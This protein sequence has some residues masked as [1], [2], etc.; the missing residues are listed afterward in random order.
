MRTTDRPLNVLH[1]TMGAVLGGVTRYICDLSNGM[2]RLGHH[3][4]ASG[5]P[6]PW[7]DL[8]HRE[9]IEWL[10][11]PLDGGLPALW[12]A[13]GRISRL[14]RER[15]ID[16]LHCH[17]RRPLLACKLA[18][19][20]GMPRAPLLYTLHLAPVPIGLSG[21]IVG[22]GDHVIAPATEGQNWITSVGRVDPSSVTLIAHGI[23]LGK[24]RPPHEDE[25]SEARAKFAV[26]GVGV[27]FVGRFEYPKNEQWVLDLAAQCRCTGTDATF[28]MCGDGPNV[29]KVHDRI[30]RDEL[31]QTVRLL[32]YVEPREVYHAADLVVLPSSVEGFGYVAAE[33]AACGVAVLRT[34]TAGWQE[35]VLDNITGRVV[36]IDREQFITEGLRLIRET[37][38]LRKMGDAG[39]DFARAHLSL[40]LQVQKTAFLYRTKVASG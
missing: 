4:L 7:E 5:A 15:N 26:C 17:F 2:H 12:A 3:C 1:L 18:R 36:A 14:A 16:V 34:R 32:G 28:L 25:R 10:P 27:A 11:L 21:K 8:F 39:A 24:W 38:L 19:L 30:R 23:D 37:S 22:F 6:G 40:D 35:T 20:R 33:A 9:K 13:A 29:S 31:G